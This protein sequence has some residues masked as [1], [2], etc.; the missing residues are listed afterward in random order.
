MCKF[1]LHCFCFVTM[2]YSTAC[3][4]DVYTCI[5]ASGKVI[6]SDRV[7]PECANRNTKV[8]KN[9]GTLKK[10][11][12]PP[13]TAEEKQKLASDEARNKENEVAELAKQKEEKY[14]LAHYNN[15]QDIQIARQKS[16]NNSLEKKRLASEQLSILNKSYKDLN[17]ALENTPSNSSNISSLKLRADKLHASILKIQIS[18][19]SYDAEMLQTN[20]RFDET[21]SRYK[22][23]I[24]KK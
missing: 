20:Q 5:T 19:Q 10:V 17:D 11:I 22:T 15:E 18:L 4:A 8:F 12:A 21:L 13:L 2:M 6:T 3:L 24:S 1:L 7:I 9:N 14:L 16:I 23:L